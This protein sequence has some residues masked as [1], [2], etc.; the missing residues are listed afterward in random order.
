[1]NRILL[2]V[3]FVLG[4][5]TWA[6]GQARSAPPRPPESRPP[7]PRAGDP[8][9]GQSTASGERPVAAARGDIRP[10]A[11]APSPLDVPLS[12]KER[13]DFLAFMREHAPHALM[14]LAKL[15]ASPAR[16]VLTADFVSQWKELNSIKNDQ[17][18]KT[19]RTN[20]IGIQDAICH[21][22]IDLAVAA[23]ASPQ[24]AKAETDLRASVTDLVKNAIDERKYRIAKL[25]DL[26]K[27][28][29]SALASEEK[30]LKA[31]EASQ[32]SAV[33]DRVNAYNQRSR[34]LGGI[35]GPLPEDRALLDL[36]F[37]D[38]PNPPDSNPSGR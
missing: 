33:Q 15:P 6:M 2:S 21:H 29:Q 17:E 4:S 36:F 5:A 22:M 31:D 1:M 3:A 24:A 37:G 30:G 9:S 34:Q 27:Q 14:V 12:P 35:M 26:I 13:Q 20:R 19:L 11:P 32:D 23:P 8:R 10:S 7:E 16:R 25:N 28:E 38:S 18:L